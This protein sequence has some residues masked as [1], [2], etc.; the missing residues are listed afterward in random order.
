LRATARRNLADFVLNL[1]LLALVLVG[2][3]GSVAAAIWAHDVA[4]AARDASVAA[5]IQSY[6]TP[7][8]TALM[9]AVSAP[10]AQAAIAV[11]VPLIALALLLLRRPIQAV[12]FLASVGGGILI[13]LTFKPLVARL[14]PGVTSWPSGPLGFTDYSFPSGHVV[15]YITCFVPLMWFLWEWRPRGHVA[16]RVA[17]DSGRLLLG[18]ALLALVLLVGVSRVYL[19]VHWPSDVVGG[20]AIGGFWSALVLLVYLRFRQRE[21]DARRGRPLLG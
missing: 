13:D 12:T 6:A 18:L 5:R 10:G 2:L 7:H 17:A 3:I 9:L 1:F 16:W 20:Y 19:G 15:Y 14:G 21:V 8:R 11:T 4:H